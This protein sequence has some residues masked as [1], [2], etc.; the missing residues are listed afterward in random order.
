MA[1]K[2]LILMKAK[3]VQ[4]SDCPIRYFRMT[5]YTEKKRDERIISQRGFKDRS[6][7]VFLY[8]MSMEPSTRSVIPKYLF[9][10]KTSCRDRDA[11][12]ATKKGAR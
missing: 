4:K 6:F 8:E 5:E 11:R 9:A 12:M 2:T 3:T 7:D 10:G 1:T